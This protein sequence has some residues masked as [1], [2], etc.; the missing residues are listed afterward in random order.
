MKMKISTSKK[1]STSI[2]DSNVG[3]MYPS[4]FRPLDIYHIRFPNRIV[5]P[6]FQVNYANID[7]TVSDRLHDF[8]L[9]MAAGGCGLIFCGA[10]VISSDAVAFDRAMRIDSDAC[11]PGLKK[12]F[13]DVEK[14]GSVPGIQLI[15]YGR[16]ALNPV[17]GRDLLAPSPIPCPVMSRVDPNYHVV[18]MTRNDIDRV[19]N[20][21]ITAAL[22]AADAGAKVVELHAAHGYLL[23]EFLSPYSNHRAD[24]YGGNPENRTRLIAE[25]ITGIRAQLRQR[26]VISVRVSGNEFVEGGLTPPDFQE[27]VVILEQAGMDLLHVSAGVYESMERIIPPASLGKTP[28]IGIASALKRF[29]TVPVCAVGSIFSIET[30]ESIISLGKAD[31]VAMGRAHVAD[32]EIVRKTATGQSADIRICI[33]CN[34]CTFWTRGEPQMHCAVNPVLRK[35]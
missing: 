14:Q 21:F 4:V 29:A 16:Q 35:E 11:L 7:G 19:R 23:N 1:Q 28:H 2:G 32:P 27:I 30:A 8:Y 18:E 12:L 13:S 22:R 26:V 34:E 25:I 10:A 9:P 31:L 3:S 15:H 6:A 24:V 5:F 17:T 33:Q 20:D